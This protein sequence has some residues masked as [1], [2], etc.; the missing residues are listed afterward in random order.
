MTHTKKKALAIVLLALVVV[1]MLL[2]VV[3]LPEVVSVGWHVLHGSST[4]FLVWEVP[5]PWGWRELKADKLLVIQKVGRWNSP[6]CDAI[7]TTLDLP[8]GSDVD[9]EQLKKGRLETE[10][11]NGRQLISESEVHLD[12]EVSVCLT[13]RGDEQSD[14]RW[15]DCDF[16]IH[17]L[18][19][20]Y[21]GTK[22]QSRI[23]NV[24]IPNIRPIK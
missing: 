18:S 8:L 23:L 1:S 21:R 20:G 17:R 12:G 24:I 15:I 10:L 14:L 16:P 2:I 5:I 7:V 22:E 11:K 6:P 13:F 9:I 3:F 4:K 19:V